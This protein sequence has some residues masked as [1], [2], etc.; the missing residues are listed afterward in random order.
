MKCTAKAG[1]PARIRPA[2][3]NPKIPPTRLINRPPKPSPNASLRWCAIRPGR[4]ITPCSPSTDVLAILHPCDSQWEHTTSQLPP[5]FS[6]EEIAA[7]LD[8]VHAGG[9]LLVISEYEHAKYGD[10]LNELLAPVGL[11]IEVAASSTAPTA[12]KPTLSG[13]SARRP[14]A[15]RASRIS[16]RVPVFIAPVGAPR[17][18]SPRAP[19][20]PPPPRRCPAI[21]LPAAAIRPRLAG[22]LR[23]KRF[24]QR[25][26]DRP[27]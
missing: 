19:R 24:R 20:W 1:Q 8:F 23:P 3:C 10:N 26:P 6:A 16:A 4:S 18:P 7:V 14:P 15:S 25:R 22:K 12:C 5:I 11:R 21:P 17:C 2:R 27:G 13:S 9:A